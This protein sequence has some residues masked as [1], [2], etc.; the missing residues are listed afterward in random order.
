MDKKKIAKPIPTVQE[1]LEKVL[2]PTELRHLRCD[3]CYS[4]ILTKGCSCG[5]HTSY[6][7]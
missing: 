1:S 5:K 2:G 3:K 6:L 7:K 4:E